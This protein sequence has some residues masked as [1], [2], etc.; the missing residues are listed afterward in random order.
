M[1]PATPFSTPPSLLLALHATL[2]E[3]NQQLQ[4]ERDLAYELWR[5]L[6]FAI[7]DAHGTGPGNIP[8]L[9]N[10]LHQTLHALQTRFSTRFLNVSELFAEAQYVLAECEKEGFHEAGARYLAYA[11]RTLGEKQAL[12]QLVLASATSGE[13]MDAVEAWCEFT[14][15]LAFLDEDTLLGMDSGDQEMDDGQ[16]G[17]AGQDE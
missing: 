11:E 1:D 16:H 13:G 15:S 6:G 2:A 7:Y 14:A 12:W 17:P 3:L 5:E 4:I 10:V 9:D 8:P